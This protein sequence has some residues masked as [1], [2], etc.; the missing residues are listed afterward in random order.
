MPN[1]HIFLCNYCQNLSIALSYLNIRIIIIVSILT[2]FWLM[3]I[4]CNVPQEK[5]KDRKSILDGSQV[6]EGLR[7]TGH[8]EWRCAKNVSGMHCCSHFLIWAL[9]IEFQVKVLLILLDPGTWGSYPVSP[10]FRLITRCAHWIIFL[11]Y[12]LFKGLPCIQNQQLRCQKIC[13]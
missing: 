4:G 3:V 5:C 8:L 2:I 12:Q 7:G 1:Y 6:L 11:K 13:R 9:R 10:A